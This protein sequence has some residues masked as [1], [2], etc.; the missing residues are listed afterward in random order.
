VVGLHIDPYSV[1][2][3]KI[4]HLS[5][6]GDYY[7]HPELIFF[8]DL[9]F[10]AFIFLVGFTCLSTFLE[11]M[12]ELCRGVFPD[13]GDALKERLRNTNLIGLRVVHYKAQ[14]EKALQSIGELVDKM[15]DDSVGQLMLRLTRIRQKK[16]LLIHLLFQTQ[17]ELDYFENRG[18]K[19]EEPP[20]RRVAEEENI[21]SEVLEKTGRERDRLE[22]YR[23]R[24]VENDTEIAVVTRGGSNHEE[25]G[26]VIKKEKKLP[27][28]VAFFLS[29]LAISSVPV[30]SSSPSSGFPGTLP[31]YQTPTGNPRSN[32]TTYPF[33]SSSLNSQ[34][35][36][37]DNARGELEDAD[38]E[39]SSDWDDT[40]TAPSIDNQEAP[41]PAM[42]QQ[43]ENIQ[44]YLRG[45]EE[46]ESTE[47]LNALE[48]GT[49]FSSGRPTQ[50]SADHSSRGLSNKPLRTLEK[51]QQLLDK[52][53]YMTTS[54]SAISSFQ[55]ESGSDSEY[56]GAT[57][58]WSSSAASSQ[59][60][61]LLWTRKD[62]SK[63]KKQQHFQE[64]LQR[65][66]QQAQQQLSDNDDMS[67]TDDGL[68]YTLPNLPVYLSDDE[69]ESTHTTPLLATSSL[70]QQQWP[71]QTQYPPLSSQQQQQAAAALAHQQFLQQ[72]RELYLAQ[73]KY[74]QHLDAMHQQYSRYQQYYPPN[75][76]IPGTFLS[77]SSPYLYTPIHPIPFFVPPEQ[78]S[79]AH[80]IDSLSQTTRNPNHF[81]RPS[82]SAPRLTTFSNHP[83]INSHS[84]RPVF[85]PKGHL[86][87]SHD[88]VFDS[89][90][91]VSSINPVQTSER[92]LV[93]QPPSMH[94]IWKTLI[95][96][97]RLSRCAGLIALVCYA[98]VSPRSL[99]FVEYN[100]RFY[101]NV[102]RALLVV[103]PSLCLYGWTV[104]D[105]SGG[106]WKS[107]TGD[108]VVPVPAPQEER[109]QSNPIHF[110]IRALCH[111]FTVGYFTIFILE[112][113]LTTLVRLAV[114]AWWEP[115]LLVATTPPVALSEADNVAVE[116]LSP[117]WLVLPWVLRERKLRVKRITLLVADFLTSCV[118]SPIVE[119]VAK[120]L[121]LQQTFPLS[122]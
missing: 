11:Q 117:A 80:G 17:E 24:V 28:F 89:T 21:L 94:R 38:D 68:G 37:D 102:R 58:S 85:P 84:F 61:D 41:R 27:F 71:L 79:S 66:Q 115:K 101:E 107:S 40:L 19:Y 36:S 119:E 114:F 99:H 23:D 121:L 93:H 54:H 47:E 92:Q 83:Q 53:D 1:R 30:A 65:H 74:H 118:A 63:Y 76:S 33:L 6:L 48:V 75:D 77:P 9:F 2:P 98:A 15:D 88:A 59:G 46:Q 4:L 60:L 69:G 29:Y 100:Q 43:T 73:Q 3:L 103:L 108:N 116:L 51:L 14:N 35:S 82:P 57:K 8:E 120:L 52:T 72:Q 78:P 86:T 62:R 44:A 96:V 34:N 49:R 109:Q 31:S 70:S 20:L 50:F 7:L 32:D 90:S 12:S 87:S 5:G 45:P 18:E 110:L 112:I 55:D 106:R 97:Q 10:W 42:S 26:T 64:Q 122:K 13:S 105:W 25:K 111:S 95:S 113:A 56:S 22:R 39:S 81:S 67:D 16:E 91:S 104:V